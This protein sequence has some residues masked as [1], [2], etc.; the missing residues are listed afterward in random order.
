[1][2]TP[3]KMRKGA[4]GEAGKGEAVCE[5]FVSVDEWGKTV[6]WIQALDGQRILALSNEVIKVFY[7]GLH[8]GAYVV[9]SFAS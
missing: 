1:M 3:P 2:V 5:A 7:Y 9:S 8:M 4:K 6:P